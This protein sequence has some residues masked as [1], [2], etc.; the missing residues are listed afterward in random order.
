MESHPRQNEFCIDAGG[1]PGGWAWTVA[2]LGARVLSIDRAPLDDKVM[3]LKNVE[4]E[5]G[6]AFNKKPEDYDGVDWLL[7]DVICY[8][9]KLL[10][11]VE[12][13]VE[14]GVV[15]NMIATIKFQGEADYTIAER[16]AKIPGSRVQHLFHN[17]HEL[18][19]MWKKKSN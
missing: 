5:K 7:S 11:W 17:K 8:P 10:E 3:K 2:K 4:F 1:S 6:N 19:W 14:S 16:F 18:T 15:N 12:R 9:E 13:W